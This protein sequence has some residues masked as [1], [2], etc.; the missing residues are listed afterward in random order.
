MCARVC[1]CLCSVIFLGLITCLSGS[2]YFFII[3]VI[4]L[5]KRQFSKEKAEPKERAQKPGDIELLHHHQHNPLPPHPNTLPPHPGTH[6]QPYPLAGD[7]EGL[8]AP[9]TPRFLELAPN[10]LA[11]PAQTKPHRGSED[12]QERTVKG[13]EPAERFP[14]LPSTPRTSVSTSRTA[15]PP[16]LSRVDEDQTE[17]ENQN[18]NQSGSSEENLNTDP[19]AGATEG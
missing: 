5:L 13:A 2:S 9:P 15:S 7:G 3:A 8:T 19:K 10:A 4:V 1:V 17:N 11:G 18:Q 6:P 12:Q 14:S 16:S